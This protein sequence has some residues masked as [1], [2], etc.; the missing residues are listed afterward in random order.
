[1]TALVDFIRNHVER[2]QCRCGKCIDAG[3]PNDQP[4]GHT[5]NLVFFEVA[6][7]D[8]EDRDALKAEFEQAVREQKPE[9]GDPV[10]LFDGNEH[11][12]MELGGWIGDQG[13]ALMTMGAGEIL[14]C[15]DVLSPINMLKLPADDPM[16]RQLAG[17]GMVTIKAKVAA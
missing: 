4:E 11:G 8:A 10:D 16:V 7:R 1:M 17:A 2:G 13:L 5:A 12:Y 6:L 14:G 9:F 15:W 3:D